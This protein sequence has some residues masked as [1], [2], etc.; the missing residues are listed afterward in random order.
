MRQVTGMFLNVRVEQVTGM[1]MS[2]T[3][4]APVQR[5]LA[6]LLTPSLVHSEAL[7]QS[8]LLLKI[9]HFSPA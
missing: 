9:R 1:E 8:N 7:L 2:Q 3:P 5:A 6:S 4:V